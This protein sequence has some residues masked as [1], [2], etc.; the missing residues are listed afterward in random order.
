MAVGRRLWAIADG[1]RPEA[2]VELA[3]I[4]NAGRE[5]V[6]IE[7]TLYFADREPVRP[8]QTRVEAGRILELEIGTLVD[9]GVEYAAVLRASG[10]VVV[11]HVRRDDG[12]PR[13]A[14]APA[15]PWAA[16]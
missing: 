15:V 5:P 12:G 16:G 8:Q 14:L 6:E 3:A 4:L 1:C 10:P 9:P 13:R 2:G 7:V 11:Q